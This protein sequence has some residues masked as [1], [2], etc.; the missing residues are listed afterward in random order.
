MK[1]ISVPLMFVLIGF[2][3]T[4]AVWSREHTSEP[5]SQTVS[6]TVAEEKEN[7]ITVAEVNNTELKQEPEVT[8]EME[9]TP[10]K[11]Q[12]LLNILWVLLAS[13]LV[14]FMQLGFMLVEV[15]FSRSKNSVN[16]MMK[17]VMDF[18]IGSIVF[19]ALGYGLMWG[20]EQG[21]LIG[22][23]YFFP[24]TE[25]V[26]A[27][28]S[29][30]GWSFFLFQCV[31]CA[32]AATIVSGAMA[33][34]TKF[35]SYLI[36]SLIISALVYPIFGAWT[37]GGG[38]IAKMGF[39]DFAGSTIVHSLGGWLAL[40]GAFMLGP[41]V[42]KYGKNG[43]VYAI[44]GHHIP[45]GALGVLFLWFGW[46][47]F[48]PGSTCAVTPDIG[49]IAITTNLSAA[50]GALA[51]LGVSWF[52]YGKSDATMTLNG[53]LAGLVGI[54]AGCDIVTP[55]GAIIIGAL[56]GVL[57][58]SSILFIDRVLKID[59]PVGAVSVHGVCGLFGTI[60]VGLFAMDGTGLFYG[61]GVHLLM[62]QLKG[63][64]VAMIWAIS[65]GLIMFGLLKYTVGLRVSRT[66]ELRG[67]DIGEHGMQAYPNFDTWTT[68]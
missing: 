22:T 9:V 10:K 6:I 40:T 1:S 23:K 26:L 27:V 64:L 33:E 24:N 11:L 58:I 30:L 54:T 5:S 43:E 56:A 8:E 20:L 67:L 18:A 41:R 31:F 14:F 63:A 60:M 7:G 15:G 21:A 17:N 55:M 13:I 52:I 39:H 45:M 16:I 29:E 42:G 51:A 34:R 35:T 62:V 49:Y 36:Y 46:F 50:A 44:P 32:T 37:W 4:L 3:A 28:N 57:V 38:W 2:I 59:D 66:E 19:F 53:I 12:Q 48:N 47:G 25:D 65:C 61:G 68:V